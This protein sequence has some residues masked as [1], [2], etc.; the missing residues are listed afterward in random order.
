MMNV[1]HIIGRV[2][3]DPEIRMTQGGDKVA[4]FSVATSERWKDKT[5]G[6]QKEHTDWHRVV[7]FNQNIVEKMI[8]PHIKKGFLVT[9]TGKVQTRD[10]EDSE[11]KTRY[12]TETVVGKFDGSVAIL[13]KPGDKPAPSPEDYGQ[14][15]TREPRQDS[16]AGAGYAAGTGRMKDQ[17]RAVGSAPM[18]AMDDEIP[19]FGEWR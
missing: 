16:A 2:G 12:M 8:E 7:V 18:R 19:F 10:F 11:G 1:H 5:T 15:R 14:T 17:A 13:D 6:E 4:S 9:V 3:K